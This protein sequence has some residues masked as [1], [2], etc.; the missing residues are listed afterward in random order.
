MAKL[1]KG[2]SFDELAPLLNLSQEKLEERR[3]RLF[4][5][6]NSEHETSIVSV[7]LASLGAVKEYREELLAQIS[8]KKIST[9]N[10]SIHIYTEIE[11]I[12]ADTRVDGLIVIT[13]GK[14]QIIE[15]A[16]IVEAKVGNAEIDKE[17]IE[18][19]T[20]FA[21]RLGIVDIITISNQLVTTPS[22]SPISL[23]RKTSYNLYHWSWTYL[24][25][26]AKRL[27]LTGIDDE[28]HVFILTELRRF[29]DDSKSLKSFGDMG[30]NWKDAITKIHALDTNKAV[31]GPILDDI[32]SSYTQEEKD[33]G[34]QLTDKSGLLVELCLKGDRRDEMIESINS[35][36]TISSVY[37]IDGNKND[38]FTVEID[39]KSSSI[40][41]CKHYVIDG[42]SKAQSK[43]TK[44]IKLLENNSGS[45][46]DIYI[47]TVYK[48]NKSIDEIGVPLS[49]LIIERGY[50]K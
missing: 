12:K 38:T 11:D 9:R 2:S 32:I 41:C 28:D 45:T 36:R 42:D 44:L 48:G 22:H 7:F 39:L 17:Q 23:G 47:R 25:V 40:K 24:K 37:M 30:E 14:N 21:K 3:A 29:M 46:E 27:I 8:S 26:M 33:N 15:W 31:K 16:G 43:T 50:H 19:Y 5:K 1:L 4:P 18:E 35:N 49:V 13:S 20:S 34:L 6:G 10:M